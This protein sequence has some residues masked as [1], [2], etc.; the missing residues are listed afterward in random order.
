M[1]RIP[2]LSPLGSHGPVVYSVPNALTLRTA[3][4]CG[5][6]PRDGSAALG[7]ALPHWALLCCLLEAPV[8]APA[9]LGGWGFRAAGGP[10]AGCAARRET[11]PPETWYPQ[12]LS[13]CASQLGAPAP[14]VSL[15]RSLPSDLWAVG[16]VECTC[17]PHLSPALGTGLNTQDVFAD[18]M[19]AFCLLLLIIPTPQ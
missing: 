14:Q 16:G 9:G 1:V 18:E 15:S 17:T 12:N 13:N 8:T 7:V 4:S 19:T 10:P 3:L 11:R 2:I 5:C 6:F